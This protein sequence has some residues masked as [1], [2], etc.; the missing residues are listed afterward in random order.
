[1]ISKIKDFLSF[2]LLTVAVPFTVAAASPN[3][4]HVYKPET[5]VLLTCGMGQG[6]AVKVGGDLYLTAHHV[7]EHM[8]C[9]IK[10]TEVTLVSSSSED[11]LA[12]IRGP[13]SID[14]MTINCKRDFVK[15]EVYTTVGFPGGFWGNPQFELP[16]IATGKRKNGFGTF[17]GE[18]YPGMSGG[19]VIDDKGRLVGINNMRW[20]ARSRSIA[21]SYLC[22]KHV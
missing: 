5:V 16:L 22:K 17:V 15:N 21:N 12:V 7:I 9:Q 1:M 2:A 20:P 13:S 11:D 10:G 8:P 3:Q 4:V 14:Y 19:A 6:S 18:I